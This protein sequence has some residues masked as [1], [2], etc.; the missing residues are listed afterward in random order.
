MVFARERVGHHKGLFVIRRALVRSGVMMRSGFIL[1]LLTAG[2]LS[3]LVGASPAQADG[4]LTATAHWGAFQGGHGPEDLVPSPTPIV[5]PGP[6]VQV[7]SSNA[8]D[9]ALLAD[10]SVYAWGL[11]GSGELGDDAMA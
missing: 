4:V 6:V 11:G 1:P 7:A 3:V 10:G 9:Y 5:L 8:T 2:L